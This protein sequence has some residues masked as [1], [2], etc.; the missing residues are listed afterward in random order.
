M[1]ES[2]GG[3]SLTIFSQAGSGH[4]VRRPI[5]RHGAGLVGSW[6]AKHISWPSTLLIFKGLYEGGLGL[7][8]P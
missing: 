4:G 1:Q 8:G 2:S 6:V 3:G 7:P 5:D